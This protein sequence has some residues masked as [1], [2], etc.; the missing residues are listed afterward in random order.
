M[1]VSYAAD[2]SAISR[3]IAWEFFRDNWSTTLRERYSD[4]LFVLP[5]MIEYL[6][7]E[8]SQPSDLREV[9]CGVKFAMQIA[10]CDIH[11]SYNTFMLR[12]KSKDWDFLK[13]AEEFYRQHG[14]ELGCGR[15]ALEQGLERI[16]AN[17]AWSKRNLP[18]VGRWLTD[19]VKPVENAF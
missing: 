13:Q 16:R 9:G 4:A 11:T 19:R 3:P 14:D 1:A 7:A 18:I 2:S 8:A 5:R 10:P 17:I 12:R 15:R 6:L